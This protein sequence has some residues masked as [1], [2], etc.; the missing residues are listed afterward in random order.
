M[1]CTFLFIPEGYIHTAIFYTAMGIIIGIL[2]PKK[3]FNSVS[4]SEEEE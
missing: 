4:N 3:K 1:I 2:I